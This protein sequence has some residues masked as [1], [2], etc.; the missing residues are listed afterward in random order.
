MKTMSSLNLLVLFANVAA[1]TDDV[2]RAFDAIHALNDQN[3]NGQMSMYGL[4]CLEHE[5]LD[6]RDDPQTAPHWIKAACTDSFA[7]R[8]AVKQRICDQLKPRYTMTLG[9]IK[10]AKIERRLGPLA[11]DPHFAPLSRATA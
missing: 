8:A 6:A 9:S 3:E 10:V 4:D 1:C 5:L 2:R 7:L 11:H